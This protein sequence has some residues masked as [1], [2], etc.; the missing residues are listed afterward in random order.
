MQSGYGKPGQPDLKAKHLT[1]GGTINTPEPK[2][3]WGGMSWH[4]HFYIYCPSTFQEGQNAR[5]HNQFKFEQALKVRMLRLPS[6]PP[7]RVP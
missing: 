6:G 2:L 1:P 3:G 7:A 5:N 4:M